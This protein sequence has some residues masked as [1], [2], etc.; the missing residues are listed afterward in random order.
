MEQRVVS[1]MA[2]RLAL[3]GVALAAL[4][5]P[6]AGCLS[7]S[8][9][10]ALALDDRK[11]QY[12]SAGCKR[13]IESTALHED[14]YIGRLIATPVIAILTAGAAAPFLIG[15]NVALDTVDRV[16][17]SSMSEA[18]GGPGKT[19]GEIA[20]DVATNAALGAATGAA[21]N[22]AAGGEGLAARISGALF[23]GTTGSG[24]R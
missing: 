14:L 11:P 13:A 12:E 3:G 4:C 16:D 19:T 2:L 23:G 9:A 10:T 1:N 18:C 21:L 5:L 22:G 24:A 20:T 6:L 17:A 15:G 7:T 8:R